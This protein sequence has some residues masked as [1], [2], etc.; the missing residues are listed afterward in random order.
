MST[1]EPMKPRNSPVGAKRGGVYLDAPT[2]VERL[3]RIL[4]LRSLG[5]GL[6]EFLELKSVQLKP[7]EKPKA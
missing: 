6:E 3:Y 7:E 5:I 2:D 1:I 4:A